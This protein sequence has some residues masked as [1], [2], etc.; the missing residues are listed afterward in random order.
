MMIDWVFHT[1]FEK[2]DGF[3]GFYGDKGTTAKFF[4]QFGERLE[5]FRTDIELGGGSIR[6]GNEIHAPTGYALNCI[7]NVLLWQFSIQRL[8]VRFNAFMASILDLDGSVPQNRFIRRWNAI[9]EHY[10]EL[11]VLA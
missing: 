10:P 8:S 6:N 5:A 3:H 9:A 11:F 7:Q 4:E 1:C 2:I